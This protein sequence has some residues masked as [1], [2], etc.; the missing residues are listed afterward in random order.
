MQNYE[1]IDAGANPLDYSGASFPYSPTFSGASTLA[2]DVPLN[3]TYAFRAIINGRY[4]SSAK[5]TLQEDPRL[6]IKPY[7]LMN[8]NVAF[9]RQD[10]KWE[11]SAWVRN[12]TNQYYWSSAATN[13]NTA[14]RFPGQDRT[15]GLTFK[16]LFH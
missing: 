4:E 6:Y 13:A 7:G 9:R 3:S 1:G 16:T 12:L 11:L 5:T 10:G 8:M 15:F 14:V 2:W